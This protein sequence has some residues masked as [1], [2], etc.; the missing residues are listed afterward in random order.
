M[1]GVDKEPEELR[2]TYPKM[3][4]FTIYIFCHTVQSANL[5]QRLWSRMKP[6]NPRT[7]Y[8]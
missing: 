6:P 8:I 3:G 7:W 5:H 1:M 2:E 4:A